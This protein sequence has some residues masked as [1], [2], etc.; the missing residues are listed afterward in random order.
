M[1]K[2]EYITIRCT[3]EIKEKLQ[4]MADEKE[5]T[6]SHTA[7]KILKEYFEPQ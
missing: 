2:K 1:T 7:E 4:K 6:L 5:W 3:K